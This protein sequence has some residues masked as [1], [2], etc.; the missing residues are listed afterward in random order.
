MDIF[1]EWEKIVTAYFATAI[2]PVFPNIT[3][4]SVYTN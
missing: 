3:C 4:I 1:Y 2:L